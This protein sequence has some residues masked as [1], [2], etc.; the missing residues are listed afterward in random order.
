MLAT[1]HLNRLPAAERG[2]TIG[3]FLVPIRVGERLSARIRH[4]ALTCVG[5]AFIALT[6]NVTVWLPDN[7][8]PITGQTLSVLVVGGALGLRRGALSVGLYIALGLFLPVYAGQ[9]HGLSTIIGLDSAGVVI[10]ARG[11]YLVSFLFAGALV[12]WL[13]EM[14]WDRHIRGAV[15]AMILGEVVIYAIGVP[16]LALAAHLSPQVAIEKGFLPFVIGDAIKLAIAAGSF[17]FA[18]WL[19]GRRAGER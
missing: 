19:V 8:V 15:A 16:W 13:A 3:D 12:G 11:G 18:W 17:P 10:G 14:G 9:Q 6:A 4:I 2:I 1:T 5:A 7:L